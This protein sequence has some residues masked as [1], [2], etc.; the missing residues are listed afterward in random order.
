MGLGGNFLPGVCLKV[1]GVNLKETGGNKGLERTE[2]R[3]RRKVAGQRVFPVVPR[4]WN[5]LP[6]TDKK[7]QLGKW[8]CCT[9]FFDV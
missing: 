3:K 6:R 1:I 4:L 8:H 9:Y 7:Q 5:S 2:T